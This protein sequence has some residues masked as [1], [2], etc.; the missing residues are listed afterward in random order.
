MGDGIRMYGGEW[1][2]MVGVYVRAWMELVIMLDSLQ[3]RG[4]K[5]LRDVFLFFCRYEDGL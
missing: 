1:L 5:F 3:V 2:G 4:N